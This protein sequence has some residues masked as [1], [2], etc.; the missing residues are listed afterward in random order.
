[1]VPSVYHDRGSLCFTVLLVSGAK[2]YCGDG[3][4]H[5]YLE[6]QLK[7]D[8]KAHPLITGIQMENIYKIH[9]LRASAV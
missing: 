3:Y 1:M 2:H 4:I 8:L 9:I 6:R 5:M 7:L